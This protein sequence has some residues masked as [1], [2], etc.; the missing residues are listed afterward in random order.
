MAVNFPNQFLAESLPPVLISSK[1]ILLHMMSQIL[2]MYMYFV[3]LHFD[4]LFIATSTLLVCSLTLVRPHTSMD[5]GVGITM[6]L[7]VTILPSR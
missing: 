2:N 6:F 3:W 1:H 5:C 7:A 4:W